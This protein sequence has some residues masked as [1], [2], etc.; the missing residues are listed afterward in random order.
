VQAGGTAPGSGVSTSHSDDS[1]A[2]TSDPRLA[3]LQVTLPSRLL[4]LCCLTSSSFFLHIGAGGW[5]REV[6]GGGLRLTAGTLPW[7]CFLIFFVFSICNPRRD[8]LNAHLPFSYL[9]VI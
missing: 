2:A 7:R 4:A 6:D 3:R 9:V 1:P 8:Y 5:R